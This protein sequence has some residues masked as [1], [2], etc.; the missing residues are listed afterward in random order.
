MLSL[1][2]ILSGASRKRRLA[3]SKNPFRRKNLSQWFTGY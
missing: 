1:R 2:V 3:E